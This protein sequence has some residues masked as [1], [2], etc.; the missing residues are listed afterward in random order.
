MSTYDKN[1]R[2]KTYSFF[3]EKPV[4]RFVV[5]N[6]TYVSSAYGINISGKQPDELVFSI[7][8]TIFSGTNVGITT[9]SNAIVFS[10]S[11]EQSTTTLPNM[12]IRNLITDVSSGTP[13]V[14]NTITQMTGALNVSESSSIMIKFNAAYVIANSSF[15]GSWRARL[16]GAPITGSYKSK[17]GWGTE[18]PTSISIYCVTPPLTAGLHQ[19]DIQFGTAMPGWNNTQIDIR[20]GSRPD[21][22]SAWFVAQEVRRL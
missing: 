17:V 14:W 13:G 1:R 3:R 7:D 9:G 4:Q 10:G 21:Y 22:Y 19:V 16:G 15:I 18:K 20:A 8:Q 5:E 6:E 11:A 2:M 12:I